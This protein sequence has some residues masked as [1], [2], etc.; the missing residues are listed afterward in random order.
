MEAGSYDLSVSNEELLRRCQE[1]DQEALQVLFRRHERPVY[2]LLLRMIGSREDAEEALADV[3]VKVWRSANK[4]RGESKFTTW[5]YR[6][7][8]NTARDALRARHGQ[9]DVSLEDMAEWDSEAVTASTDTAGDPSESLLR[10][11]NK[12]VLMA[13]LQRVSDDDRLLITL[14]HLQELSYDEM[15]QILNAPAANLKVRLFRARQRL[16]QQFEALSEESPGADVQKEG[17]NH[18]LRTDTTE[19]TGIQPPAVELP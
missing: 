19:S 15:S 8:A 14:Y 11:E 2:G 6:I 12:A 18:A 9:H 7:S 4:F 1:Q 10:S 16:R 17:Q 5:L 13:A 3:F